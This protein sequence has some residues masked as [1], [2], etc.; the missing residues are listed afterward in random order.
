VYACIH[1]QAPILDNDE[2]DPNTH[3]YAV[4]CTWA[5]VVM[6]YLVRQ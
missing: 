3:V 4:R 1:D 2:T 6:S 5:L